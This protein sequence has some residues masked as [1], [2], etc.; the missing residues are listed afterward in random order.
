MLGEAHTNGI[1]TSDNRVPIIN[2]T[3]TRKILHSDAQSAAKSARWR[4]C[5]HKVTFSRLHF[6][7]TVSGIE[8]Q[9]DI[10]KKW[11]RRYT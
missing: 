1:I 6:S 3:V 8:M 11:R 7:N 10:T 9:Q 5:R 2:R 4:I